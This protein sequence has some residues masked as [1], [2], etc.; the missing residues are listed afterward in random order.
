MICDEKLQQLCC[1]LVE[2]SGSSSWD[3]SVWLRL[4]NLAG[5]VIIQLNQGGAM[6]EKKIQ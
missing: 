5:I 2:K 6:E 1:L 4:K 3:Y